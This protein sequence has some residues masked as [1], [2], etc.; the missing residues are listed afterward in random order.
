MEDWIAGNETLL[1]EI[2]G[3]VGVGLYLASY[4][5]LQFGV[6]RGQSYTY[7]ALNLF[8]AGFVLVSLAQSFNM[9]SAVIQTCWIVISA[10]GIA[11]IFFLSR[12]VR[13]SD[14][15]RIFLQHK[16]PNVPTH[17]ARRFLDS[18]MWC[19]LEAGA[20]LTHEGMPVERLVYIADGEAAVVADGRTVG[21]VRADSLIGEITSV[22]GEPA[23]ASATLTRASRC[24]CIDALQLRVLMRKHPPI[25]SAIE[26]LVATEMQKKIVALNRR[27]E[28]SAEATAA[29]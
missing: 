26:R 8:A 1:A 19:D 17:L 22:T 25:Q 27:V 4:A 11:R 18:G 21:T 28:E 15:E 9:A 7:P 29:D 10:I 20:E 23:T 3:A 24:F 12:R 14:E 16:M 13:F 5:A 2:A 6:I